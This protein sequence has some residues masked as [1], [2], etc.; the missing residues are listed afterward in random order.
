MLQR[1]VWLGNVLNQKTFCILCPI[2]TKYYRQQTEYGFS[3][4]VKYGYKIIVLSKNSSIDVEILTI[5]KAQNF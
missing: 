4:F 2:Y 1:I 5:L 3:G